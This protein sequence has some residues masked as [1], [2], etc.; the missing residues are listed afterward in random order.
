MSRPDRVL[1]TG[2]AGF[3]GSTL[4][5]RL[6]AEGREVIGL[7]CFDPFYAE[8]AKRANLAS[9]LRHASFR[10]VEADIRDEDALARAFAGAPIGAVVHLAALAGVR[11]SLERPVAYADVNVRGTA[12][13]AQAM[14]RAEVPQL[15]FASSSSVYGERE[16][17]PFRETDPVERPISPYAATKRAGELLLSS[18]HYAHGT[19][20][21]CARIFTAYGPRQRPDLAI[22]KFAEKILRD[23]AL[24]VFGDGS[25]VRDFTF[26]EDLVGG[27]VRAI[28]TDLGFAILNFGAGRTVSVQQVIE[29]LERALGRKA[30]IEWLPRQ[31]GD[32]LRT[33]SDTSAARAALGYA[34]SVTLE[35]GVARFVTWLKDERRA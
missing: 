9:A 13:V 27:L 6:L 1:V 35:E 23:E 28:D 30:R 14:V 8:A 25:A 32:V 2:A 21:T 26:V 29:T 12:A 31:T 33:W 18:F 11:P 24:P 7:D 4:V 22:R 20:I 15:V 5:D 34:P 19:A 17:G 10:L 16:G 3:I